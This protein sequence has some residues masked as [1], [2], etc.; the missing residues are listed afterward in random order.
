MSGDLDEFGEIARLFQPLTR[1]APEALG[2][3]DD[4]AAIPL[5]D[6]RTLVITTDT[7]VAGVHTP[8]DEEPGRLARKL[9]RVNLS[10][11][12]AKGAELLGWFLN[13]AW[14]EAYDA[15]A[16]AAFAAGLE[17]DTAA[18]D[19]KLFGGDTVRTAGPLTASATLLGV[20]PAGAFVARAGARAGDVL[21]VSGTIG[22]AALG[23][24]VA[25][26]RMSEA[27]S[28]EARAFLDDRYRL[29]QPR[30]NLRAALRRHASACADVS[31]GLL[32]DAGSIATAS[33]SA[34]HVE[35]EA[36]PLSAAALEWLATQ[37]NVLAALVRLATGGDDY[38]LACA[39]APDRVAGFQ[40][41]AAEAGATLTV[42]GRFAE[43]AGVN[44]G[45]HGAPMI[46]EALGYRHR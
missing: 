34:V 24:D 1:G 44:V 36:V 6:G 40:A 31:D 19:L 33:K 38:E 15:A 43:G 39:C 11:L 26:G 4:A 32:A 17:T 7:L 27:L 10:D 5:G 25:L 28:L 35:L 8:V 46:V 12:A 21:L 41:A 13:V 22:D 37:A 20:C 3:L 14:P 16:R 42:V 2:L 9:L 29:P 18:F 30:L 45:F 23:L